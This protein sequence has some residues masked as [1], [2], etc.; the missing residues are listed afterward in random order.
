MER[1]S[2]MAIRPDRFFVSAVTKM[3]A[4]KWPP[5]KKVWRRQPKLGR[6]IEGM[7]THKKVNW[8][9]TICQTGSLPSGKRRGIFG[10]A[11]QRL[12]VHG[13]GRNWVRTSGMDIRPDRFF[14]SAVTKM[15]AAKWPPN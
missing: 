9:V 13:F 8:S 12:N 10:I 11:F 6:Q 5:R 7:K 4:A 2:G 3:A 1:T 15:A 14:V